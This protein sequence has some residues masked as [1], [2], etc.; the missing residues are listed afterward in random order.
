MNQ[1]SIKA[2]KT[3]KDDK[4]KKAKIAET[5]FS[6]EFLSNGKI[7]EGFN[8]GFNS[9]HVN[10][11]DF[12][13][14]VESIEY[15]EKNLLFESKQNE[16]VDYSDFD[17]NVINCNSFLNKSSCFGKENEKTLI[18]DDYN[19]IVNRFKRQIDD[20]YI[21]SLTVYYEKFVNSIEIEYVNKFND[22]KLKLS[23][24]GLESKIVVLIFLIYI[25]FLITYNLLAMKQKDKKSQLL[26]TKNNIIEKIIVFVGN[27]HISGLQIETS[28]GKSIQCFGKNKNSKTDEEIM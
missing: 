5:N 9:N 13:Y 16:L 26:I 6:F 15:I 1:K 4:K 2:K 17:D 7:F 12:I 22:E 20:Y 19:N 3:N 11:I 8:V 25:Y 10:N 27:K 14:R 23:H 28:S 18:E 24:S 21:S